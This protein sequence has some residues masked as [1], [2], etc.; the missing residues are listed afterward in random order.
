MSVYVVKHINAWRCF[1][2]LTFKGH[3]WKNW[4]CLF[5]V[6]KKLMK[7]IGS[8]QCWNGVKNKKQK[9]T[10]LKNIYCSGVYDVNK[11]ILN[12]IWSWTNCA[13]QKRHQL[14]NTGIQFMSQMIPDCSALTFERRCLPTR[15]RAKEELSCYENKMQPTRCSLFSMAFLLRRRIDVPGTFTLRPLTQSIQ[16]IQE[17]TC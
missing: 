16:W 12:C 9:L 1:C 5:T 13:V 4:E 2:A 14:M 6:N 8:I 15:T 17:K 3:E 7:H 11:N 10:H